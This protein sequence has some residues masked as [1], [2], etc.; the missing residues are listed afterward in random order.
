MVSAGDQ[1]RPAGSCQA[2]RWLAASLAKRY[3]MPTSFMQR[4]PQFS[5][6]AIIRGSIVVGLPLFCSLPMFLK[7]A[8]CG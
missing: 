3:H 4:Q 6:F 7:Q 5:D 2:L 8:A 1:D